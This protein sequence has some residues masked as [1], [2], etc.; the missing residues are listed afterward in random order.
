MKMYE[1]KLHQKAL[2]RVF[3]KCPYMG[4]LLWH[5]MGLG[6]TLTALHCA[7]Y[8]RKALVEK[9][10]ATKIRTL[11]I[12][13]KSIVNVWKSHIEDFM[14]DFERYVDIEPYSQLHNV[15]KSIRYVDYRFVIL[16]ECHNLRN[17]GTQ[18]FKNFL[19]C[20]VSLEKTGFQYGRFMLL[21]GTPMVNSGLD[22]FTPYSLCIAG[23]PG[24]AAAYL[25]NKRRVRSWKAN[26]TQMDKTPWGIKHKGVN[27]INRLTKMLCEITHKK[28]LLECVDLPNKQ[29][30][31]IDL[32][33]SDDALLNDVDVSVPSSYISELEALGRAKT[34]HLI[35]Y[36]K[37]T[38]ESAGRLVV[39]SMFKGP[40]YALRDAV[41][42]VELV[43][44]DINLKEKQAVIERFR[45][46]KTKVLA[47][48]YQTGS[49]G[50]NLQMCHHAIYHSYPWTYASFEQAQ[51]RIHR[52][53]QTQKTTH[54]IIVSGAN[55]KH[56]F[57]TVM[58]KKR[59]VEIVK[60]NT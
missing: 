7:K 20:L 4:M 32:K 25:T 29:L 13:P 31:T 17:L 38:L 34:P 54:H 5:E 1:L 14:P 22:W 15:H 27:N 16:D 55:D 19:K 42:G 43:T 44:G 45:E 53:G 24:Q 26:F 12:C 33:L 30:I 39:F 18:R 28:E 46:G 36:V 11:V 57:R 52:L 60:K 48:T 50:L 6:K 23:S 41:E 8:Y 37:D 21:S 59:A 51:A 40:L 3:N 10:G 9:K 47:M 56:I 58:S 2:V 49:E 35:D